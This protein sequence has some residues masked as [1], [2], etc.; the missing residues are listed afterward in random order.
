ML[1][2][3]PIEIGFASYLDHPADIPEMAHRRAGLVG[4]G[5]VAASFVQGGQMGGGMA[6]L[7]PDGRA[8]L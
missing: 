8:A 3:D 4:F 6:L 7:V 1:S 2:F 5:V